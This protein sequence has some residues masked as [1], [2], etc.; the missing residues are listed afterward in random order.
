MKH[1]LVKNNFQDIIVYGVANNT[2]PQQTTLVTVQ[3]DH[4]PS[5]Q[6]QPLLN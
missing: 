6:K 4:S 1:H 3:G 2:A 5:S